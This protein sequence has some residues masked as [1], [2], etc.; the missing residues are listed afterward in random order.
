MKPVYLD[1]NATTP[2]DER[3]LTAMLP[4]MREQQSGVIITISSI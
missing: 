4:F 2:L 3:V 1:H